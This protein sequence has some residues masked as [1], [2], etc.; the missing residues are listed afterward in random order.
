MD[1]YNL[2]R[3]SHSSDVRNCAVFIYYKKHIPLIKGDDICTLDKCLATE[4]CLQN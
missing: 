4:T 2:I 3:S 1:A